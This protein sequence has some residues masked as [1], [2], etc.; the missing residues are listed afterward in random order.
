MNTGTQA[1]LIVLG[2]IAAWLAYGTIVNLPPKA[3]ATRPRL[4]F[5][6]CVMVYDNAKTLLPYECQELLLEAL[7]KA[8]RG[9][10]EPNETY[11]DTPTKEPQ[12]KPTPPQVNPA[13]PAGW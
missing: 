2:G 6:E 4:T 10:R 8:H 7:I 13:L 1:R 5:N 11:D 3:E 9:G 12:W